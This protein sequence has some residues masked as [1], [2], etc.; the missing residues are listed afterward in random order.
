MM[1][2]LKTTTWLSVCRSRTLK[3]KPLKKEIMGQSLVLFRDSQKKVKAL[4]DICPHKLASLS[5]GKVIND[6]IQCPY[7]G[8]EFDGKGACQK[9]P[10]NIETVHNVKTSF[11]DCHDDGDFIYIKWGKEN[12]VKPQFPILKSHSWSHFQYEIKAQPLAILDNGFDCSHTCFVHSGLYRSQ[13]HQKVTSNI[14]FT[15]M[16][17]KVTTVE[18]QNIK[19][20]VG[21]LI[22]GMNSGVAHTD[23]YKG[24]YSLEVNYHYGNIHH[25]TYLH[26]VPIDEE[27]T[28]VIISCGIKAKLIGPLL[29]LALKYI[30]DKIIKQDRKILA[31]QEENRKRTSKQPAYMQKS[32]LASTYLKYQYE[33]HFRIQKKAMPN[34][35]LK[36]EFFL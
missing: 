8:W 23:E 29:N 10:C 26:A 35:I 1:K 9:I 36:A 17:V 7:H 14:E 34:K 30:T 33:N 5:D 18:E 31:S 2:N 4:D 27:R 11:Y 32:D 24:P 6:N 13:P 20:F 28:Q 22:P 21:R 19:S 25:L 15:E 3:K 12:I 16:G